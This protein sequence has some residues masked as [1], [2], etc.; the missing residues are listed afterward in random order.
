VFVHTHVDFVETPCFYFYLHHVSS[1]VNCLTQAEAAN[2]GEFTI[3][4]GSQSYGP[5]MFCDASNHT[6]NLIE[7]ETIEELIDS[8][9]NK[10][11]CDRV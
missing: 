11:S 6:H 1:S 10:T 2:Y 9:A 7:G 3:E 4:L 8:A 5:F